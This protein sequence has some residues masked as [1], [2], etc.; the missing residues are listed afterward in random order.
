MNNL[1]SYYTQ[2]IFL[3]VIIVNHF[4]EIYLR[5]RQLK[6]FSKHLASA[7]M[8]FS[9]HISVSDHQKA[10]H[11]SSFK[12][13]F[14]I[15]HLVFDAVVLLCW[16]PFRGAQNL[17][18]A[19]PVEGIHREVLFLISFSAIQYLIS[20][21][22]NL[23][24]T[25]YI[26]NKF[27]FNKST[28]KL[29][30]SDQFKGLI[31]GAIIGVPILYAIIGLYLNIGE[32][33]WL[34]SFA[35]LT[36]F[37]FLMVLIYPTWIAPLF[38]KFQPLSNDDLKV[39]IEKLVKNAGFEAREIFVMDASKR[40]SHGNAYFTGFGKNKRVVF[41][42]TLISKLTNNEIFA[43]LAH[44]LGHMKLK[45]IP[46]SMFI[47]LVIS[48]VGFWIM[49]NLADS[50]WFYTGHFI[51]V[52]SPGVLLLLFSQAIPLYTFWFSPIGSWFSRRN[53]FEADAYAAKETNSDDLISGL[54]KLYQ[55]N[56]SPVVTD[57][58]FSGFYHSHPPALTRI[59]KL[60]ALKVETS[61]GLS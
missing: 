16:F 60:N 6:C 29:F 41:F 7:P 20:L 31:L 3:T 47:S 44:E 58:L 32:Y 5:R 45:H 10:I 17:Y 59:Q 53:E 1:Y 48:F 19:I 33:W 52:I 49:G 28:P 18:A 51:K 56:A 37:Q 39:G 11:Y 30:A 13:K 50:K 43:I 23:F 24:S 61:K 2:I 40:S 55:H 25:F 21:P 34:A 15:T 36:A 46:K 57:S 9:E 26:E 42:D 12:L 8:E 4:F 27:G 22:W 14:S 54:L 35:L 38:N